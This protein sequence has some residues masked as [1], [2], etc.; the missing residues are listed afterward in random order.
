MWTC[1]PS[2]LFMVYE[3]ARRVSCSRD[4]VRFSIVGCEPSLSF[5]GFLM[6]CDMC[7]ELLLAFSSS[8]LGF[9]RVSAHE[10]QCAQ[11]KPRLRS[12]KQTH[13]P[14]TTKHLKKTMERLATQTDG[15]AHGHNET[16]FRWHLV[17][18]ERLDAWIVLR[19]L[20]ERETATGVGLLQ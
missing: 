13:S 2:G 12:T 5:H 4:F 16:V 15:T 10:R 9:I 3:L 20:F 8:S 6:D 18:A 19:G 1:P 7:A 14:T 17:S 11:W